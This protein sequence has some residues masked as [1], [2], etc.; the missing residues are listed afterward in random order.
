VTISMVVAMLPHVLKRRHLAIA[1]VP[2]PR[3][4]VTIVPRR[5]GHDL[6]LAEVVVLDEHRLRR[7]A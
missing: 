7:P 5:P 3:S 6:R 1:V 4:H 2:E